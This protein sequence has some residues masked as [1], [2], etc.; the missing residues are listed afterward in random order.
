ME[1]RRN[2][3]GRQVEII[4]AYTK[5]AVSAHQDKR[6]E[7][8]IVVLGQ[9]PSIPKGTVGDQGSIPQ[10]MRTF[11]TTA[12]WS[13]KKELGEGTRSRNDGSICTLK[14]GEA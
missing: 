9:I 4:P 6:A 2:K 5:R 12:I 8:E 13:A 14:S 7:E 1:L 3:N 11:R 10:I